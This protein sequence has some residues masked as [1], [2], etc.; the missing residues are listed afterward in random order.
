M[1]GILTGKYNDGNIPDGSRFATWEKSKNFMYDKY[2]NSEKK[3]ET[4]KKLNEM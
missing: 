1:G 2:F 4:M 3:S